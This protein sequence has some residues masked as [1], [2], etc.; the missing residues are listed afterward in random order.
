MCGRWTANGAWLREFY[1]TVFIEVDEMGVDALLKASRRW[2]TS[3]PTVTVLTT[4]AGAA[5]DVPDDTRPLLDAWR[6]LG[7]QVVFAP[8]QTAAAPE[9]ALPLGTWDYCDDRDVFAAA[10]R[11]LVAGGTVPSAARR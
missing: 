8:W 9:V 7:L 11:A 5:D 1:N 2:A 3:Q 4:A 10:A 6:Q